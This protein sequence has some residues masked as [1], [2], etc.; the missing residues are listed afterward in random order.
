MRPTSRRCGADQE[1]RDGR[2]SN[3]LRPVRP[4]EPLDQTPAVR[5]DDDNVGTEFR[6]LIDDRKRHVL[7]LDDAGMSVHVGAS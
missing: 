3:D 2:P 7:A 6:A 5:A 1:N 4:E